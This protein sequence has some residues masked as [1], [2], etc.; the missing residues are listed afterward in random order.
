MKCNNC[1][2]EL[3]ITDRFCENCGIRIETTDGKYIGKKKQKI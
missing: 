1:G 3:D 2:Y